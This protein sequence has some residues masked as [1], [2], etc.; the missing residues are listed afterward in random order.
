[1]MD[2]MNSKVNY[3]VD[4]VIKRISREMTI[5]VELS[6]RHVHLSKESVDILFGKGYELTPKRELSQ[7]GQYL[8][9]EKVTL[10]GPNGTFHNVAVLGPIRSITQVELSKTDCRSLGIEAPVRESGDIKGS[11][12]IVILGQKGILMIQEG[13]IVAK[14]HL[15]ITPED[16]KRFNVKDKEIIGIEI[17]S[18]RSMVLNNVVVRVN[19]NYRTRIHM[20][21]DEGNACSY[22]KGTTAKI[23][24]NEG[25]KSNE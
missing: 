3:I 22:E 8:C 17:I 2:D 25:T 19:E 15:H 11:A 12:S 18:D 5:P 14:R 4:E 24:K 23:I 10:I 21:Y 16:A 7:P 6:G 1:M 13:V 9:H 20:D